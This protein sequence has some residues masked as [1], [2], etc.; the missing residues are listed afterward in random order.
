MA[1]E[2]TPVQTILEEA[3]YDKSS[4]PVL[5]QYV[6]EQV[7]NGT[8][9]AEA[10]RYTVK[11]Y[12]FYPDQLDLNT[13]AKILTKALTSLPSN[14]FLDCQYL[15]PEHLHNTEPI[16]TLFLLFQLLDSCQYAD[17]W[18]EAEKARNILE[19]VP[20]FD[21]AVRKFISNVLA[22]TYQSM[23]LQVFRDSLHLSEGKEEEEFLANHGWRRGADDMIELPLI[24]ENQA[25]TKTL[26]ESITLERI[27]ALSATV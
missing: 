4:L 25:K 21:S 5:Q 17:F 10:N 19:S 23:P 26:S 2:K 22:I 20:S 7:K 14:D 1:D 8:Y 9:D 12:R 27:S 11:L 24:E 13:L 6:D 15:I 18:R 16:K 3:A